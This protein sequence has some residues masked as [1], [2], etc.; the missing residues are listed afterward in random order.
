[1][2]LRL[3]TR[4][5]WSELR[6]RLAAELPERLPDAAFTLAGPEDEPCVA[7]F[8]GPAEGSVARAIGDVP[9]WRVESARL[10]PD[11]DAARGLTPLR[12]DRTFSDRSWALA[13]VRFQASGVRPFDRSTPGAADRLWAILEEDDPAARRWPLVDAITDL[14]VAEPEPDGAP[15]TTDPADHWAWKLRAV[16]YD[17]LWA[18]AWATVQL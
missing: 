7:W 3:S 16:G 9:G 4:P 11:P 10:G 17:R 18:R 13:V 14:L 2:R 15:A 5:S 6:A 1:M 12:L 8:E